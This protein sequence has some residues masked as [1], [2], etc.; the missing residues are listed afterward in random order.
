MNNER[1]AAV[2]LTQAYDVIWR[3]LYRKLTTINQQIEDARAR[4]E[5][6][7]QAWLFRQERYGALPRQVDR[8]FR[9]FAEIATTSITRQQSGAVNAAI[10]NSVELMNAAAEE[11]SVTATFNRLPTAAVENLVGF[12]GNGSPLRSLIDRLPAH[13]RRV[14]EDGLIQAV[15]L[16]IS[17][18]ETARRIREGLGGT[19]T[20]ALTIARTETARAYNTATSQSY[21]QNS[22]IVDGWYWRSA[23]GR[24]SCAA[25]IALDGTFHSVNEPMKSH[26]NCRCVMIPAVEGVQ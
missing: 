17:P 2:R 15:T 21:K 12:L 10:G 16:G 23:R 19:L 1:H 9:R 25:C 6:V 26:P 18:R 3:R 5:A 24:R 4:G 14:I 8:E 7:N 13:A 20:R 22:D 11:A